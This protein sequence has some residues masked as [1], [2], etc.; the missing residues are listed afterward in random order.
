VRTSRLLAKRIAFYES[1][2]KSATTDQDRRR[3]SAALRQA[4]GQV[5]Q[6]WHGSQPGDEEFVPPYVRTRTRSARKRGAA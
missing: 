6:H 3:I 4:R 2:L 1:L 5:K